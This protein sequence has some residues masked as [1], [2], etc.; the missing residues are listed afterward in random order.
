[1]NELLQ[2]RKK[3]LYK[4]WEQISTVL[5]FSESDKLKLP[6]AWIRFAGPSTLVVKKEVSKMKLNSSLIR[7]AVQKNFY[8]LRVFLIKLPEVRIWNIEKA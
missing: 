8:V 3:N 1:M 2:P 7:F 6:P 5:S 4:Q